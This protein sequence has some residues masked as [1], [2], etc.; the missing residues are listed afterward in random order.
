VRLPAKSARLLAR[1]A[2]DRRGVSAIEF[3]FIAPI[4]IVFYFGMAET[5]QLLIAKRKISHSA[6]AVADLV[7]QSGSA[8]TNKANLD[9]LMLAAGTIV[10][11]LPQSSL[12]MRLISVVR[13]TGTSPQTTVEWS[14]PAGG[15]VKGSN[16]TTST[17]LNPGESLIVATVSYGYTSPVGYFIPG[18]KTLTHKAELRPRKQ[19]LIR[20]SDCT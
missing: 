20:C 14:H 16:Y 13:G 15:P 5:C 19:D 6:A 11:P 4:L 7:S 9:E 8:T 17:P 12:N 10:S 1:F 2:R 18:V 3:A